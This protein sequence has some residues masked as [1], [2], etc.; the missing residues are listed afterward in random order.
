MSIPLKFSPQSDPHQTKEQGTAPLAPSLSLLPCCLDFSSSLSLS[1]LLCAQV[2]AL[3]HQLQPQLLTGN[4]FQ[5]IARGLKA[6]TVCRLE[7][8]HLGSRLPVRALL[9]VVGKKKVWEGTSSFVLWSPPLSTRVIDGWG[10]F[11]AAPSSFRSPK[12]PALSKS[13][14]YAQNNVHCGSVRVIK[15]TVLGSIIILIITILLYLNTLTPQKFFFTKQLIM[16]VCVVG[17]LFILFTQIF[18]FLRLF[19]H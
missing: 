12:S 14:N 19:I 5:K 13:N 10:S 16:S 3:T 9:S 18:F 8:T 6:K 15:I 11:L 4:K 1:L 7:T 2:W 17:Y